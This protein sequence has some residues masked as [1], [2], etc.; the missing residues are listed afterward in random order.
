MA[1]LNFG[2][3]NIDMTY[4]VERIVKP[5]QTITSKNFRVSCGGK[6]FNQSIALA[7]AGSKVFHAGKVGFDGSFII[8]KLKENNVDTSLISV[9]SH[10]CGRA[11][12]QVDSDGENSII[13]YGG[14]NFC[15]TEDEIGKTFS[16]FCETDILL[17]QN[18][19][20]NIPAIIKAAKN[21]GMKIAF[22]LA[23]FKS[24]SFEYPLDKVD[25][26]IVNETEGGELTGITEPSG[27]I[28]KLTREFPSGTII[29]TLGK[30]GLMLSHGSKFYSQPS[31]CV[32]AVDTTGAGDTF[33]GYFLQAVE[34]GKEPEEAANWASKASALC[35][36][37]AG[38]SNSIP[39]RVDVSRACLKLRGNC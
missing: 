15:I 29:L 30:G 14:S 26:L 20:N 35:V 12:I 3:L 27:I 23:P 39:C 37:C 2:S 36:T 11:L 9:S 5:G 38:S 25:I 33:I 17:I 13:V 32:K 28:E 16:R 21:R 4:A 6:G 8:D 31:Y 7:K 1:I 19:I 22:N 34:A 10:P 18:E 24:E